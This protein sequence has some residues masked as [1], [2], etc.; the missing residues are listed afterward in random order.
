MVMMLEALEG[1]KE[2]D[3]REK[4]TVRALLPY[5]IHYV[6]FWLI[7]SKTLPLEIRLVTGWKRGGKV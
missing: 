7:L 6:M 3:E 5:P 2:D 4:R 1:W